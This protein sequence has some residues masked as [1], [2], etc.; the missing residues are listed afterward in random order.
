MTPHRDETVKKIKVVLLSHMADLPTTAAEAV[1]ETVYEEVFG[2]IPEYDNH[3]NALMCPY[4]NRRRDEEERK[5]R[6]QAFEEAAEE[7]D[8]LVVIMRE[9]QK[10]IRESTN[11]FPDWCNSYISDREGHAVWLRKWAKE[12]R[13]KE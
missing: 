11:R 13:N 10:R 7:M 2:A 9:E 8:R 3:H 5:I 12:E 6:A 4:C 1:S